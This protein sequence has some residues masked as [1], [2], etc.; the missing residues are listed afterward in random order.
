MAVTITD[1]GTEVIMDIDQLRTVVLTNMAAPFGSAILAKTAL[2]TDNDSN[3]LP[4]ELNDTTNF[5]NHN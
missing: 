2:L 5:F 3:I 1:I 4:L